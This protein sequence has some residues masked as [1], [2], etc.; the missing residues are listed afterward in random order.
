MSTC[1]YIRLVLLAVLL[2]PLQ[3]GAA[4][5]NTVGMTLVRIEPGEYLRGAADQ[6]I[7][8]KYHPFSTLARNRNHGMTPAH[9]VRISNA[10]LIGDREVTVAQFRR[11]VRATDYRTTSENSEKGALAF[12][13]AEKSGL[14]QFQT[15][16]D[17]TWRTP[18]FAQT[19]VHPV[20]CV[21]WKDA[22]TFCK[23]LSRKEGR[24]YRLPT[25]AEWEYAARAG[26]TTMF[27][28][29]HEPDSIYAYGN[30]ADAVLERAH[31]NTVL[32]QRV[33][34]LENG[35][36]DGFVYTA[37]TGSLK[38]NPWGLYDTHGN[39]WEWCSDRYTVEYYSQLTA[40]A[41]Q[42]GSGTMPAVTVDPPGPESTQNEKYGDWRAI[43]GGAWTNS[44]ITA[45]CAWRGFGEASDA[46]C[47]TGFRVV[48]E[49]P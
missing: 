39:V 24:I 37:P 22:V 6:N 7:V 3:A 1:E 14:K 43:R 21:S 40:V 4:E 26:T 23:W 46:S 17:C 34:A 18:G 27:I 38:P 35:N 30:V 19:D 9:P 36:G 10:F 45:R 20:V 8:G 11:F 28:G 47:Y 25:E 41:R 32:R 12:F 16:S 29:G 13:S 5:L 42:N 44:P 15:K 49:L 31:P 48:A 2:C 33:A